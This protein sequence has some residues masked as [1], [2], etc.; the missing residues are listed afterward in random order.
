MSF[1]EKVIAAVTPPESEA[2][3]RE[4][5]A[6]ARGAAATGDWLSQVLEH[7][8]QIETAFEATKNAISVAERHYAQKKL[9][10]LLTGHAN[11]EESVLY[12]AL[13]RVDEKAH[14]GMAYNEQ[15]AVKVQMSLLESLPPMSQDYLDKLEQIRIAVAHHMYEEEGTW[16]LEVRRKLPSSEQDQ[17]AERYLAE[18]DRCVGTEVYRG[19]NGAYRPYFPAA[20]LD[21]GA[22]SRRPPGA[23]LGDPDHKG[24]STYGW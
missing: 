18:F 19:T 23:S 16:F 22:S 1:L 3:R 12:P 9:A 24:R 7:H 5:R 4:A 11:A 14:A 13:S 10:L 2:A 8:Q 21:D 20:L 6:K 15:A 17:L